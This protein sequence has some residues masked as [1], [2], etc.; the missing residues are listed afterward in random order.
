MACLQ[1]QPALYHAN[2][3]KLWF[4]HAGTLDK[5]LLAVS[6]QT[7]MKYEHSVWLMPTY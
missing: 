7:L 3:K 6:I 1:T 2:I 4:G 5:A